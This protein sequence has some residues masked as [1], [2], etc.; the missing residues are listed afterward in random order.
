[1]VSTS[2]SRDL[3]SFPTRRSSDLVD[4]GMIGDQ[5]VVGDVG[6][7]SAGIGAVVPHR[8]VEDVVVRSAE[9]TAEL[10]SREDLV[11]RLLIDDDKESVRHVRAQHYLAECVDQSAR[12]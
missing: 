4:V 8:S 1:M 7:L 2:D 6:H 3:Y 9:H 11:R 10:Q 5:S 12:T